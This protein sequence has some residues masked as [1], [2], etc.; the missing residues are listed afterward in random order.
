MGAARLALLGAA[1]DG[2]VLAYL[3]MVWLVE[4]RGISSG[5]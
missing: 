2:A 1:I 3:L 5:D 4:V